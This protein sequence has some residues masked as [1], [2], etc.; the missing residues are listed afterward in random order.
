[1]GTRGFRTLDC[2]QKLRVR[3]Y[4]PRPVDRALLE[5]LGAARVEL[6]EFSRQVPGAR[7][8]A[9]LHGAGW[10]AGAALG[11]ALLVVTF[12]KLGDGA[13]PAALGGFVAALEAAGLGPVELE[14]RRAA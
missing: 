11:D 6:R 2:A 12:G 13:E 8:H 10:S 4:L 5:R 7:D 3:F 14:R 1:M 9:S